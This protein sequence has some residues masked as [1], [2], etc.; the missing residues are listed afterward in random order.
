[1]NVQ[2]GSTQGLLVWKQTA[3]V[4]LEEKKAALR[5][6]PPQDVDISESLL[7]KPSKN[8]QKAELLKLQ[9]DTFLKQKKVDT[10]IQ[11]KLLVECEAE[12]EKQA[13][14]SYFELL[15]E[16]KKESYSSEERQQL[17]AWSLKL[18]LLELT[19]SAELQSKVNELIQKVL[20]T[21]AYQ[22]VKRGEDESNNP[23]YSLI[24]Q[25]TKQPFALLK[26]P[27]KEYFSS[28]GVELPQIPSLLAPV[29]Q[30]DLMAYEQTALLGLNA[31][32][33]VVAVEISIEETKQRGVIQSFIPHSVSP[34]DAIYQKGG[35][36]LLLS[37]PTHVAHRLALSS[38]FLGFGAGHAGNYLMQQSEENSK[39]LKE[40]YIIDAK[41]TFIPF[42]RATKEMEVKR[43][44]E[45]ELEISQL[46]TELSK[47]SKEM[48]ASLY[49]E[50]ETRIALLQQQIETVYKSIIVMRLWIL[51]LNQ[52][53]QPFSRA[54]LLV[55][56]HPSLL[57]QLQ[58]YYE[59][60][61]KFYHIS[62]EAREAQLKRVK[63][64]QVCCKEEL[65]KQEIT[66]TPR[67]LFFEICGGQD[68][69]KLGKEKGYA[70]LH[71]F[72]YLISDPYHYA[73]KDFADRSQIPISTA[74]K[75][76][77]SEKEEHIYHFNNLCKL[78]NL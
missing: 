64:M 8:L 25:E 54:T 10:Q 74:L 17:I 16:L 75:G 3:E 18:T 61:K 29:W 36:D 15:E 28:F 66:L 38:L 62:Q 70:D 57:R 60:V 56:A 52:N 13:L 76:P 19:D 40:G 21:K 11:E 59:R 34:I 58:S 53:K 45:I 78:E 72:A 24:D 49:Q 51:G 32:P 50:K 71:I 27:K 44:K 47:L 33:P 39:Q 69:Y 20:E 1:M 6:F 41:E 14:S 67:D 7:I 55:F 5:F 12:P 68:L 65:I 48:D 31:T 22:I 26:L 30:H 77:R 42:N 43:V 35:A 63:T 73:Q 23:S 4:Q 37:L 2:A 9:A 46:Q